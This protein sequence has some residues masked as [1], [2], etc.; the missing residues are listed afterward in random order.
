MCGQKLEP[1][2]SANAAIVDVIILILDY[3]SAGASASSNS[4]KVF[5]SNCTDYQIFV[6][7]AARPPAS[8]QNACEQLCL[9]LDRNPILSRQA[10]ILNHS[11]HI[12]HL[13]SLP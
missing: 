1:M 2:R 7:L 4:Q 3:T 13:R 6:P 12:K 9:F 8:S 5:T 10:Q 11:A